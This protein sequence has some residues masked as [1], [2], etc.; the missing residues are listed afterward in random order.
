[1][2]YKGC[3]QAHNAQVVICAIFTTHSSSKLQGRRKA[4]SA[5]RKVRAIS[6]KLCSHSGTTAVTTPPAV[7]SI[8]GLRTPAPVRAAPSAWGRHPQ[9]F[10]TTDSCTAARR[11]RFRLRFRGDGRRQRAMIDTPSSAKRR[12]SRTTT[13]N[14]LTNL[15]LEPFGKIPEFKFCAVRAE[16][17]EIRTAAAE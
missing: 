15:A 10:T 14:L 8:G 16:P 11:S 3:H 1:M 17:A 12:M 9:T 13:V 4:F 2:R 6:Q 7:S 5:I